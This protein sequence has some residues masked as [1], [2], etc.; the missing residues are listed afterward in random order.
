MSRFEH[1]KALEKAKIRLMM[2]PNTIFYTTILFSL[3]QVWDTTIPTAAVN[4]THLYINPDWFVDL[5]LPEAV[6]LL[7][8]EA[9]HIGLDHITRVGKRDHRLFNKAGDY[10]I[11]Q[12]LV[13]E[14]YK[15][16]A[17]ALLD[18]RFDELNTEGAYKILYDEAP[19]NP[20]GTLADTG[21]PVYGIGPDL[22]HPKDPAA[23]Q[24]IQQDITT[25]VLRAAVQAKEQNQP[26]GNIAGEAILLI[27][28]VINP[29]LP[30]YIILQNYLQNFARDDYSWQRPNRRYMPD[31]YLP[32]AYSEAVCDVAIAVDASGS[33]LQAFA[34]YIHEIAYLKET[35]KPDKI[36]LLVF[37]TDIQSIQEITEN[38]DL[39]RDVVFTGGGG[40]QIR[41]VLAWA[42]ENKPDVMLIFTDGEF[43]QPEEGSDEYPE[44]PLIWIIDNDPNFTIPKG[45]VI[46]Y[47]L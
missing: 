32:S 18:A 3:K 42:Q 45:T 5:D 47:D 41:P 2:R 35:I 13:A 27:D 17:G 31:Y 6:G 1:D 36:T 33:A 11:N 20:D 16:P 44:T 14:G 24:K 12:S 39:M 21:V 40:T 26:P 22:I 23:A 8:H 46:N 7:A 38:T 29:K 10:K 34:Y 4:G 19:K 43:N 15:L 9:G 25:I 28:S 30:W 37:D